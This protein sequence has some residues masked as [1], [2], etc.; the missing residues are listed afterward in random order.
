MK[1][2]SRKKKYTV[3]AITVFKQHGFRLSLDEVAEKMGITKKTLYNH[4]S[5]RDELFRAC[6]LS[7]S[8]DM[9]EAISSLDNQ[10]HSAIINFRIAF[11]KL[12][13]FFEKLSPP[14]FYDI[15]KL[16]PGQAS[17]QHIIGSGYFQEKIKTNLEQG[18]REEVYR[19][20]INVELISRYV[21]YSVFG[22]Y[23]NSIIK[24]DL[25]IPNS[26]FEDIAEYNLRAIVSEKGYQ[27]L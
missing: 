16:N 6:I 27:L 15:M 21:S 1:A 10:N 11:L 13:L 7:I 9:Q 8:L 20:N 18:L 19:Q 5:S 14:F 25:H 22:F 17:T 12:S 3:R 26:Y 4:F 2:N 24:N 23:I